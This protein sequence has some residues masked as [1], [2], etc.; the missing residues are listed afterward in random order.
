MLKLLK[1]KYYTDPGHGWVA[2]KRDLLIEFG[3]A[4]KISA[5]S[6]AKGNTV[7]LEEDQ[8]AALFTDVLR[9]SGISFELVEK[10]TDRSSP[11]RNYPSYSA[12]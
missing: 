11:I 2:V 7:Y 8:D 5:F 3:V 9:D 4:S 1:F 12:N 10:Y 6:Y